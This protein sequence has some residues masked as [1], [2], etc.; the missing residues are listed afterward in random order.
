MITR[1]PYLLGDPA[2]DRQR[3]MTQTLLF[4]DYVRGAA[5]RLVG[6]HIQSILDLGCGEGQLGLLL[7]QLYSPR[8]RLMGIDNDE[9]AIATARAR[10]Q[11]LGLA[12]VE[13][14][15]GDAMDPDTLAPGAFDLVYISLL[16]LHLRRPDKAIA[17]AYRALRPGGYIWI[18]ELHPDL[19]T[20]IKHPSFKKLGD[21]MGDT[22]TALGGNS[23]ISVE[24][25]AMLTATGFVDIQSEIE[26]YLLGGP[27]PEGQATLATILGAMHHA[28]H[29]MSKMTEVPVSEI[30]R[31]YFDICNHALRSRKELGRAPYANFVARRPPA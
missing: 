4:S 23:F 6:T 28:R 21:I 22:A 19:R 10:A 20:A 27:T 13:F 14:Q 24:V 15:V 8:P 17:A 2:V 26:Y 30:E 12:N 16:L 29:I 9:Q 18:K 1:N 11:E 5:H 25:P 31:L 7:Q 3:L